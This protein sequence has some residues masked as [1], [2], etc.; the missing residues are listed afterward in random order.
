MYY[1]L[2]RK[3]LTEFV[4]YL[5]IYTFPASLY[6]IQVHKT[7]IRILLIAQ[8]LISICLMA[9]E[10]RMFNSWLTIFPPYSNF[11]G[12]LHLDSHFHPLPS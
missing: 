8:H 7:R 11:C 12:N 2:L 1:L 10:P 6:K 3:I 9:S 5:M 4:N